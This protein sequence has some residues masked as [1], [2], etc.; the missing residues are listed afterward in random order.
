MIHPPKEKSIIEII[1]DLIKGT[2][3]SKIKFPPY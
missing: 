3:K 1:I 2:G